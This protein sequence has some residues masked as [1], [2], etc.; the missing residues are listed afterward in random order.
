MDCGSGCVPESS[1]NSPLGFRFVLAR[2]PKFA[3]CA[4]GKPKRAQRTIENLCALCVLCGEFHPTTRGAIQKGDEIAQVA[5][6][7]V[8]PAKG[9]IDSIIASRLAPLPQMVSPSALRPPLPVRKILPGEGKKSAARPLIFRWQYGKK[10]SVGPAVLPSYN[11]KVKEESAVQS[12]ATNGGVL[13][14]LGCDGLV[15]G[16]WC[17][18]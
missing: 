16:L 1:G 15:C 3:T 12:A 5:S 13:C 4:V 14:G 11:S 7:A 10:Y 6:L 9:K 8:S 17:G 18:R 2:F